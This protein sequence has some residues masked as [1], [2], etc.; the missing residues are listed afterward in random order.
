MQHDIAPWPLALARLGAVG[1]LVATGLLERAALATSEAERR[2]RVGRWAQRVLRVLGI[3]CEVRGVLPGG[4]VLVVANHVSWLDAIVLLALAPRL[5]FVAKADVRH[6]P[7]V[8]PLA[9]SAGTLFIE[10]GSAR[11]AAAMVDRLAG[12]LHAGD[13]IAVF[14]EGTTSSGERVAP[15]APALFE[16][17]CRAGCAV[18]PVALRHDDGADGRRAAYVDDDS[19]IGSLWRLCRARGLVCRVQVL[20]A[21]DARGAG[22]RALAG[23]V[24]RRLQDGLTSRSDG[25]A[26]S[27]SSAAARG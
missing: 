13:G 9:A 7:L 14:P 2:R 12:H 4:P 3:A 23:R 18:Q 26:S 11:A 21:E 5:R 22:R 20:P 16:A 27:G 17:A 10:R 15:L 1:A 24:H 25:P 8:G 6:W 19:F